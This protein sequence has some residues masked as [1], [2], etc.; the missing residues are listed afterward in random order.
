M[1]L[2]WRQLP[3]PPEWPFRWRVERRY[4]QPIIQNLTKDLSQGIESEASRHHFV[5]AKIAHIGSASP[6]EELCSTAAGE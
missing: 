4:S 6:I 3:W 5:I 2:S 1:G